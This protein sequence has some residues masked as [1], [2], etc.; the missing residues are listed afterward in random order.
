MRTIL[1]VVTLAAPIAAQHAS[2]L[3]DPIREEFRIDDPRSLLP[4]ASGMAVD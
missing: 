1:L 3:D 4:C 2:T